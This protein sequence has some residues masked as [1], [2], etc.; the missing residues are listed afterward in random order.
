MGGAEHAGLP[1]RSAIGSAVAVSVK[2][3]YGIVLVSIKNDVVSGV[4]YGQVGNV[5][6]LRVYLAIH[7]VAEEFAERVGIYIRRRKN[8]F[9]RV[10]ALVGIV[11]APRK[12][13]GG[14]REKRSRRSQEKNTWRHG[15]GARK[16]TSYFTWPKNETLP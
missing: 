10:L 4:V 7:C 6:R 3:V 13:I 14:L 5:E 16:D 9:L 11:I 1:Q 12:H 8:R 15:Y 2:R